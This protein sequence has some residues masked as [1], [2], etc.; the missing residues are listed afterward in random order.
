M[1]SEKRLE[2][3][4]REMASD[5]EHEREAAEWCDALIGNSS[6]TAGEWFRRLDELNSEPFPPDRSQPATPK[7][8]V[9]K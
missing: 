2:E 7:L 1:K 3:G 8:D 6:E 5:T 4:Y 9:F